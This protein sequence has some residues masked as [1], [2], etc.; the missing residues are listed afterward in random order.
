MP[1]LL[2][3]QVVG[4]SFTH[5]DSLTYSLTFP[6]TANMRDHHQQDPADTSVVVTDNHDER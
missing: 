1:Q 2:Q 4:E 3:L 5:T 6:R